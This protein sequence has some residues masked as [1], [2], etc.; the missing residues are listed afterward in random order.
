MTDNTTQ[1]QAE[2]P[3]DHHHADDLLRRHNEDIARIV[4]HLTGWHPWCS[5]KGIL[6]ATRVQA[7][8]DDELHAGLF[9]TLCALPED[10]VEAIRVE[11]QKALAL[12][13]AA[14]TQAPDATQLPA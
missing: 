1:E 12:T 4:E 7:L 14:S 9:R 3:A 2:P 11:T 6:Y 8:N 5:N 13:I 10:M